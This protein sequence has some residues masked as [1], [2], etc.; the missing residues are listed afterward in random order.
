M[1]CSAQPTGLTHCPMVVR[2]IKATRMTRK[3]MIGVIFQIYAP[4]DDVEDGAAGGGGADEGNMV[5]VRRGKVR[6][7]KDGVVGLDA[8]CKSGG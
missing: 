5:E 3:G 1:A 8:G 2:Q 4:D 7:R 6:E